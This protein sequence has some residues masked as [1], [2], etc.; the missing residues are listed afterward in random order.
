MAGVQEKKS[1][2]ANRARRSSPVSQKAAKTTK[3]IQSKGKRKG[4]KLEKLN[5]QSGQVPN[6]NY[7]YDLKT[8]PSDEPVQVKNIEVELPE[9]SE[10]S[11]QNLTSE[12]SG[13]KRK[14]QARTNAIRDFKPETLITA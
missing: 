5:K 9:I 8:S 3:L 13:L 6:P 14:P 11:G 12:G 10:G 1:M 4:D 2:Q 7:K